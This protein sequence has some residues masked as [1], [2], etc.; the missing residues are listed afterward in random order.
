MNGSDEKPPA[1]DES[2]TTP[3]PMGQAPALDS[4]AASPDEDFESLFLSCR[5]AME[6]FVYRHTPT[7]FDGD[8][9]IQEVCLTALQQFHKEAR[10]IVTLLLLFFCSPNQNPAPLSHKTFPFI[11]LIPPF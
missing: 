1:S 3:Q 10:Q 4:P 5:A 11:R 6:R 9:V 7:Q 2:G 8:D